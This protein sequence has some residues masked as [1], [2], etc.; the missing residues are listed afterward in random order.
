[1][2]RF[3]LL[4]PL[5]RRRCQQRYSHC[6]GNL[7]FLESRQLLAGLELTPAV[8][9]AFQRAADL[10]HYSASQLAGA[11]QWVVRVTDLAT[12]ADLASG[13]NVSADQVVPS[14]ILPQT[15]VVTL[16]ANESSSGGLSG[17]TAPGGVIDPT[18]DVTDDAASTQPVS[19]DLP[20]VQY[21]YPLVKV[22][23]Q[24]RLMWNDPLLPQQWHLRERSDET[25]SSLGLDALWDSVTGAGTTIAVVDEGV[26]QS[27]PDLATAIRSDLGIDLADGDAMPDP[28]SANAVHGTAVAGLAAA[29]AD[30]GIGGSGV[31]PDAALA[32][33]RLPLDLGQTDLQEATAI[34]HASESID[35][36]NHSWGPADSAIAQAAGPLALAAL[37]QSYTTARGGLGGV[38]VWASGNGGGLGDELSLDGLAGIRQTIAVGAVGRDG[39]VPDYSEGG[40]ALLLVAPSSGSVHDV[41]TTDRTGANGLNRVL[42]AADGDPLIDLDYTSQFGG[43]S[44]SAPLVSGTVALLLQANPNLTARDIQHILVRSADSDAVM[45]PDW[46]T[47]GAGI[48]VSHRAGFGLVDPAAAYQLARSWQTLPAEQSLDS[49]TVQVN[50]PIADD[51]SPITSSVSMVE[52]LPADWQLDWVEVQVDIPHARR[53]D[54]ELVLT[55]PAGTQSRLVSPHG[56]DAGGYDAWTFASARHWGESLSGVWTLS[57]RD[58]VT[59]QSGQWESWSLRFYGNPMAEDQPTVPPVDDGG[60]STGSGDQPDEGDGDGTQTPPDSPVA[61]T[62][63]QIAGTVRIDPQLAAQSRSDGGEGAAGLIVYVDQNVD[64]RLNLGELQTRTDA[65]GNYQ[66]DDLPLGNHVVRIAPP[67]G[68]RIEDVGRPVELRSTRATVDFQ[69]QPSRDFGDAPFPYATRAA[70]NGAVH[71]LGTSLWL[72]ATV[73]SEPDGVGGLAARSDDTTGLGDEDGVQFPQRLMAGETAELVVTATATGRLQA[74]IDFNADG[75]WS[76]PFEQVAINRLVHAG[77]NTLAI[78]VPASAL[79]GVTYARFRVSEQVDIGPTGP[80]VGGEVEDYAVRIGDLE[81][82]ITPPKARDDQF[83]VLQDSTDNRLD[84]LANDQ[85]HFTQLR[86]VQVDGGGIAGGVEIGPAGGWLQYTPGVAFAGMETFRYTAQDALGRQTM[87]EVHV[88][89]LPVVTPP[90]ATDDRFEIQANSGRQVLPVLHNDQSDNGTIRV[91]AVSPAQQGGAAAVMAD[92]KS[93]LYIPPGDFVGTDTFTYEITDASGLSAHGTVRVSVVPSDGQVAVHLVAR[94]QAGQPITNVSPGETFVLSIEVQDLRPLGEGVFAAYTDVSYDATLAQPSGPVLATDHYPNVRAGDSLQPGRID[95][96]GGTSGVRP[97]GQGR[98]VLATQALRATAPGRLSVQSDPADES[99]LHDVLLYGSNQPL[100][101]DLISFGRVELQ[102]VDWHNDDQPLDV[103]R[104]GR[105]TPI[106]ALLIVN[107]LNASG[108]RVLNGQTPLDLLP[109][110][111]VDVNGDGFLSPIDALTVVNE[112]NLAAAAAARDAAVANDASAGDAAVAAAVAGERE[113]VRCRE[114]GAEAVTDAGVTGLGVASSGESLPVDCVDSLFQ[115]SPLDDS[116]LTDLAP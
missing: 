51:G 105:V 23:R 61:V 56:A 100:A 103:N 101:S 38:H 66:F 1:M 86:V 17:G 33:V 26:E 50:Q 99:P 45:A 71:A 63:G 20:I 91:I 64:G 65:H 41:V 13:L 116:F 14:G 60:T 93:I 46:V 4:S 34:L 96:V 85:Q 109:L 74:W 59:G 67:A 110:E 28:A 2:N 68:W 102:V 70:D 40:P 42:S 84:V 108:P 32:V 47:N 89:V 83:Q 35:V 37:E 30:N 7:E 24:T 49:G 81:T 8:E 88:Q 15:F 36:Y 77:I 111:A 92:G 113:R 52:D 53:G 79:S 54:L 107:Q 21:A 87:A 3:A 29:R 104:D 57:V 55:S 76:D 78:N 90:S 115:E 98:F 58:L 25:P 16:S 27:H 80:A 114:A 39:R 18:D 10:D 9:A 106:D 44:A 69:V 22:R 19:F 43:T 12:R 5:R 75:D 72:G 94:D 82:F 31:A 95:E 112:L 6:L 11:Q 97:L 62:Q 48:A 73:D